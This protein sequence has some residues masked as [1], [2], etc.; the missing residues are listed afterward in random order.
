[1]AAELSKN[2]SDYLMIALFSRIQHMHHADAKTLLEA[3][4]ILAPDHADLWFCKAV[5]ESALGDGEAALEAIRQ[6]ERLEP[7]ARLD[8]A[9][10]RTRMRMRNYIKARSLYDLNGDLGVE[11]RAAL[12]F[13]LRE[14]K[15]QG[16]SL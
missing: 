1:M 2:Q 12:D 16:S 15:A 6:C 5:T 7:A 13:Y 3:A 4:L 9:R 14:T 10:A 11:G 8:S